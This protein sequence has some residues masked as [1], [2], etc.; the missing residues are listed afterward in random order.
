MG[1]E[2]GSIGEEFNFAN[3][4][5]LGFCPKCGGSVFEH[6][7]QFVC[8]KA[9]T[10]TEDGKESCNFILAKTVLKQPVSREQVCKLLD[11][12]K[13]DLFKG[14]LSLRTNRSF[15]ARLIWDAVKG[16]V[17]FQIP[18]K[19]EAVSKGATM[20]S[21]RELEKVRR[22]NSQDTLPVCVRKFNSAFQSASLIFLEEVFRL[23][24]LLV[25]I[26]DA[27][28]VP[29]SLVDALHKVDQPIFYSFL[30]RRDCPDW[31]GIWIAKYGRKEQQY[32]YLFST[33]QR[34]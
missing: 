7:K 3:Q 4:K 2:D 30:A 21:S 15:R 9:L 32:A 16:R 10:S 12:G 8:E 31:L 6:G 25:E 11:T 1:N 19:K 34:Y 28:L 27:S 23:N 33:R 20:M 5:S 18:K 22:K 24:E 17:E 13:T 29:T 14:F 26:S